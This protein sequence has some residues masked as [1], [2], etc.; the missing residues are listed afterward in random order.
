MG[1]FEE[2]FGVPKTDAEKDKLRKGYEDRV[3]KIT[4]KKGIDAEDIIRSD[5]DYENFYRGREDLDQESKDKV[6]NSD[7]IFEPGPGLGGTL[8]GNIDGQD[9]EIAFTRHAGGRGQYTIPEITQAMSDWKPMDKNEALKIVLEHI[10]R[11]EDRAGRIDRI[12]E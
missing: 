6:I 7:L 12:A 11:A 5:A 8:K 1:S 3:Q 2:G 10:R 9:I 4:I